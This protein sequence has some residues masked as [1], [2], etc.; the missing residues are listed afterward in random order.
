VGLEGGRS[1]GYGCEGGRVGENCV[2]VRNW[3]IVNCK[4][5]VFSYIVNRRDIELNVS[6]L[7]GI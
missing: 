1:A 2:E 3:V 7:T 6:R 4:A 5:R